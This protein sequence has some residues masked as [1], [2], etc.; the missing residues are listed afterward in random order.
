[1][2]RSKVIENLIIIPET[3]FEYDWS[4]KEL[5]IS[6]TNG[7][8][9]NT[10]YSLILGTEYTDLLSNKPDRAFSL[11]FSSGSVIDSGKIYGR[12]LHPK[13]EGA[14]IF[15]YFSGNHRLDTLNAINTKPD[16]RVQVGKNGEFQLPAL[17]DGFY[18]LFAVKDLLKNGIYDITDP[19]GIAT[20]DIAVHNGI[21][22]FTEIKLG[23]IPDKT[24]P[25]IL[26]IISASNNKISIRFSKPMND[27]IILNSAI[28]LLDTAKTES[29]K[30]RSI[31][32]N[33]F[34]SNTY[35][36][37]S[38]A[39]L[40]PDRIW[41]ISFDDNNIPYDTAGNLLDLKRIPKF[42][43][44]TK[45][46]SGKVKLFSKPFSDSSD[47]I[48]TDKVFD[49]TF[50]EAIDK[51]VVKVEFKLTKLNELSELFLDTLPANDNQILIASNKNLEEN[52]SYNLLATFNNLKSLSNGLVSDT[53]IHLFFKTEDKRNTGGISGRF[54]PKILKCNKSTYMILYNQSNRFIQKLGENGDF[55]FSSIPA[56]NYNIELFCDDN[57]NGIYDFGTIYPFEFSE[58]F[59]I[60]NKQ[61]KV[62]ERW[63]IDNVNILEVYDAVK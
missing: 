39:P 41:E 43:V 25:E 33:P 53:T 63:N 38:L 15:A 22:A 45:I 18:R 44:I 60:H 3:L 9:E 28:T 26:S 21:A 47:G 29:I 14:Y 46:D 61:L 37:I 7:L 24:L 35:E 5:S 58:P 8:A 40:N 12:I 31:Y 49:F 56:D 51:N 19:F 20:K 52:T 23:E 13:P 30:S 48:Q 57:D 4:G 50:N 59:Y 27:S 55:N 17:K 36:L 62:K 6:F 16:Y 2:E 11:V 42:N 1:M 34:T 32:K 54:T 10:T